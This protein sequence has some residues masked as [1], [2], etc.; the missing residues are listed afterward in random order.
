MMATMRFS[1]TNAL[2][3]VSGTGPTKKRRV[4]LKLIRTVGMT[5]SFWLKFQPHA[6]CPCHEQSQDGAGNG[7]GTTIIGHDNNSSGSP[8]ISR[9]TTAM[10]NQAVTASDSAVGSNNKRSHDDNDEPPLRRF[11]RD[12]GYSGWAARRSPSLLAG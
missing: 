11:K 2:W 6:D 4:G 1:F 9:N 7:N 3:N 10:L 12:S 5:T 8:L